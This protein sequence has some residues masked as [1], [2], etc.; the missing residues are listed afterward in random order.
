MT[1]VPVSLLVGT[2]PQHAREDLV[3]IRDAARLLGVSLQTL[4]RW[5]R[6]GRLP[7][8]QR[9]IATLRGFGLRGVLVRR[10]EG[11]AIDPRVRVRM[12]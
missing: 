8:E 2:V 11:Y 7:A 3:T 4:R 10:G 12:Q 5:D 1:A 6:E 9:G